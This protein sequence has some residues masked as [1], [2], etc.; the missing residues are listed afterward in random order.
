M[1]VRMWGGK[2]AHVHCWWECNLVQALVE[3][4]MEAPQKSK[5][6]IAM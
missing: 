3:K 6:G 4:N 1:L 2:G 5:N